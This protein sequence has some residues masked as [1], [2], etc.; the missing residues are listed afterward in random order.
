MLRAT[1]RPCL[2]ALALCG[3]AAAL[4]A[5]SPG[6][7]WEEAKKSDDVIVF[8]RENGTIGTRDIFAVAEFGVAPEAVFRV[9]TDYAHYADFMPYVKEARILE[10][11]S[12]NR[13]SVY[14]HIAPPL[15]DDRDWAIDVQ[16]TPGG[17]ANGGVFKT[18]WSPIPDAVPS[19]ADIVRVRVNKGSW[20]LEPLDGGR[21]T[22]VTYRVST[23]PGGS[24]P[25]WIANKS[26]T[27]AIPDL[28]KAVRKR[29]GAR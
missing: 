28:F 25:S 1:L 27:V 23:H 2:L 13:V 19:R 14:A 5:A 8:A 21:R 22:R 11:K 24:I 10:R 3:P 7:G 15:V 6:P 26:N 12:A 9:V 29:S 4:E 18:E 20:T 17:A 16:L